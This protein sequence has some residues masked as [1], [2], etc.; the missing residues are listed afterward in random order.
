MRKAVQVGRFKNK[1]GY[2]MLSGKRFGPSGRVLEHRWL[3]EQWLGRPLRNDEV[4]HHR[5][6]VKDDNRFENLEVVEWGKHSKDHGHI[7][8]HNKRTHP[9]RAAGRWAEDFDACTVCGKTDKHPASEGVCFRCYDRAS[10]KRRRAEL[11]AVPAEAHAA[12]WA[13]D[14]AGILHY[15]CRDCG[16]SHIRH[17]G[18]GYCGACYRWR[19]LHNDQPRPKPPIDRPGKRRHDFSPGTPKWRWQKPA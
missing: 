17:G 1:Q 7:A 3:M 5:N 9:N 14:R 15:A 2:I 16:R 13:K 11:G 19:R 18:N 6:G 4:V 10:K 8:E 12:A